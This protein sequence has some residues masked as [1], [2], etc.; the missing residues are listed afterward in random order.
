MTTALVLF[1]PAK[2]IDPRDILCALAH[3]GQRRIIELGI[4]IEER[5]QE[6]AKLLLWFY[7][8]PETWQSLGY[9]NFKDFFL[10]EDIQQALGLNATSQGAESRTFGLFLVHAAVPEAAIFGK[11]HSKLEAAM[12]LL[13]PMAAAALE[14]PPE[15]AKE[16]KKTLLGAVNTYRDLK[17]RE[18]A[19]RVQTQRPSPYRLTFN[20]D[21]PAI[22]ELNEETGELKI[23]LVQTDE[24]DAVGAG[25]AMA[26]LL[27]SR[28]LFTW[29]EEGIWTRIE[30]GVWKLALRWISG[31]VPYKVKEKVAED[32]GAERRA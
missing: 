8:N 18:V 23:W 11:G 19:A 25:R 9:D 24:C 20:S 28:T 1:R 15:R 6:Q 13:R 4:E 14:A 12:P 5:E 21:K 22:G 17:Y 29:D 2:L 7:R 16:L 26:R 10:Q 31:D 27:K 3:E 32:C 30:P